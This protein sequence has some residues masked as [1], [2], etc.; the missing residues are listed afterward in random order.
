MRKETDK[1]GKRVIVELSF[2]NPF[3]Q[4]RRTIKRWIN[5]YKQKDQHKINFLI[6]S[7]EWGRSDGKRKKESK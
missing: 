3:K 5:D 2:T 1:N 4:A 6:G 7:I